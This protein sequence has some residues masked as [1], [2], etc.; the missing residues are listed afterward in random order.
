[1]NKLHLNLG[2]GKIYQIA[3]RTKIQ[4]MSY[5]IIT[6]NNK[7]VIIDGGNPCPE[8]ALNLRKMIIENGGSVEAWFITHAHIDHFGALY[9]LM[10][11]IKPFDIKI[12]SIYYN[13]P[14]AIW[15][16]EKKKF[17][18][19]YEMQIDGF[20]NGIIKNSIKVITPKAGNII[21]IDNIKI[22]IL[23]D[24]DNYQNYATIND[25]S[26]CILVYFPNKR[27]LF[28]ADL[29]EAGGKNYIEN[30]D[31]SKLKCDIVQMAHHG[32]S[33]VNEE[34][35]SYVKPKI[36]LYTAPDWLWENDVELFRKTGSNRNSGPWK[37][38]ETREWMRKI[39][40]LASCPIAYGDY[41]FD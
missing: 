27:I 39:D 29:E 22:E 24:C 8:D 31:V 4:M 16:K 41:L 12:N 32:Q 1:M 2:G 15:L 9:W 5:I 7:M 34:F 14:P 40:V 21:K 38:L 23:N 17:D 26:I 10:E 37:T 19:N 18:P 11:N 33:G 3:N 6:E 30:Y 36:C 25:T 20:L 13:F 35:Y 28:L